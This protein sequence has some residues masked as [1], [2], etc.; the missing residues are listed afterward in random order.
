[1]FQRSRFEVPLGQ[2]L[3]CLYLELF[4]WYIYEKK[5]KTKRTSS[6]SLFTVM[7]FIINEYILIILLILAIRF[8]ERNH[9]VCSS[10]KYIQFDNK[11]A[12]LMV[13]KYE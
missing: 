3:L 12:M 2:I 9:R 8:R 4:F 10:K 11:C 5:D 6:V 13:K 7:H 1:M